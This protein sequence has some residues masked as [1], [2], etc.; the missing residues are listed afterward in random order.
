MTEGAPE[1]TRPSTGFRS[2]VV[3]LVLGVLLAMITARLLTAA[4][5]TGEYA[6]Q[7]AGAASGAAPLLI[8]G[9][10]QR[11]ELTRRLSLTRLARLRYSRPPVLVA[12]VFGFALLVVDSASSFVL[13]NLTELAVSVV[14]G[15][16]S[17]QRVLLAYQVSGGVV[18]AVFVLV[19]AALL[20]RSAAYRIARA[21]KRWV[22]FGMAVF[23]LVRVAMLIATR[24]SIEGTST[25]LLIAAAVV[26]TPILGL[27]AM[28]GVWRA[29]R[30][31][32]AFN[33]LA[34]FRRLPVED[35]EAALS[36]L[37]VDQAPRPLPPRR[38]PRSTPDHG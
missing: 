6:S 28:V 5:W 12:S 7:T 8:D 18:Q 13:Y 3:A 23:L 26:A 29:N 16:T 37:G 36:L 25:G 32:A 17:P 20:G 27:A 11:R 15:D 22:W 1:P 30:T 24:A 9:F 14:G 4:G 35:Q 2:S 19:M 10:R 34:Y 33:A 38:Q 21:R 31:Q